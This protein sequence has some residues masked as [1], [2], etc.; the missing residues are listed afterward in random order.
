ML[1]RGRAIVSQTMPLLQLY[2]NHAENK[3]QRQSQ[4]IMRQEELI[5]RENKKPKIFYLFFWDFVQI[6]QSSKYFYLF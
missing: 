6:R 3:K 2:K 4:N 5:K 1:T